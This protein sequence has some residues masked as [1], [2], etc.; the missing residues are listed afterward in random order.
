MERSS[1]P[2]Q[3]EFHVMSQLITK[4]FTRRLLLR[5]IDTEDIPLI[6][7]WSRSPQAHGNYLSMENLSVPQGFHLLES[8]ALWNHNSRTYLVEL[9]EGTPLGTIH[10]W[11]RPE[12]KTT[13]VIA[14]KIAVPDQRNMG[15]GTEAQKFLIMHLFERMAVENVEM[16]T[17]LE[18]L[19]QQRC[20][21][22]LGFNIVESLTYEDQRTRRIGYLYRLT[23]AMYAAHPLYR[24]HYE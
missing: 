21:L 5:K 22:K 1:A 2:P 24:Y 13:A 18:N 4:I 16:Y 12:D 19:A 3:I 9:R 23:Q 10:F 20:L 11:I 6:V 15:Y 17:D 14:L 7:Y 8:G